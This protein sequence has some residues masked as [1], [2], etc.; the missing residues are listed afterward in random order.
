ML[1]LVP[2]FVQ[3]YHPMWVRNLSWDTK[4]HGAVF[5]FLPACYRNIIFCLENDLNFSHFKVSVCLH[6]LLS[7]HI[8]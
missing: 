8:S 3:L 4:I 7:S 1:K 5:S 2:L 6:T